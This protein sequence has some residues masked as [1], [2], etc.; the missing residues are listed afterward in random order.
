M[1]YF[2]YTIFLFIAI[3]LSGCNKSDANQHDDENNACQINW[4]KMTKYIQYKEDGKEQSKILY[5]YD[6]QGREVGYKQYSGNNLIAEWSNFRYDG[7]N[8]TYNYIRYFNNTR[9]VCVIKE[10][11]FDDCFTK[12]QM[13]IQY[14]E[15]GKEQAKMV[16]SYDAK[17]RETGY[18]QYNNGQLVTENTNY[19]YND[20][21][22]VYE[23]HNYFNNV[24]TTMKVEKIYLD[25]CFIKFKSLI[26]W[27]KDGA[28]SNRWVYIY[29]IEG[30]PIEY[31]NY[32]KGSLTFEYTNYQYDG[33]NST[34]ES[35]QYNENVLIRK[36]KVDVSYLY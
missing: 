18:V 8:R 28:E 10:T 5:F 16:Y 23:T 9:T 6:S 22:L 25:Y 1:N 3:F 35:C 34:Y 32:Y 27:E 14:D 31:K 36:C 15:N 7:L 19:Q 30:K 13:Y 24:K 12:I 2:K 33:L 17:G 26:Y 29:D 11:S 20:L 21:N 4:Y